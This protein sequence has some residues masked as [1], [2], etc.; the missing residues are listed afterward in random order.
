VVKSTALCTTLRKR[1]ALPFALS[2]GIMTLLE[3]HSAV[4]FDI[5]SNRLTVCFF[6]ET[7]LWHLFL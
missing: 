4:L 6:V 2:V 5:T 7:I 1:S 3:R